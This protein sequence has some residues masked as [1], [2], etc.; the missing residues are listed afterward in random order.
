M[1]TKDAASCFVQDLGI[2]VSVCARVTEAVMTHP[3]GRIAV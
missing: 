2:P 3:G 1:L